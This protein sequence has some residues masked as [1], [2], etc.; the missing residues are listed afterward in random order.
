MN[1]N[2]FQ[3]T[4]LDLKDKTVIIRCDAKSYDEV[5]ENMDDLQKRLLD[6]G[7]ITVILLSK[8]IELEDFSD[9]ELR[10]LGFARLQ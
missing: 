10:Q 1:I 7:A 3:I 8:G 5:M 6:G 9:L 2:E 4:S